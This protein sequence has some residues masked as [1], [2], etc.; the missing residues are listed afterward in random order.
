[1]YYL[2]VK[3]ELTGIFGSSEKYVGESGLDI[4]PWTCRSELAREHGLPGHRIRQQAG[5]YSQSHGILVPTNYPD[6]AIFFYSGG[7]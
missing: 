7:P 1:M 4:C 5:S 6:E 2:P 3:Q